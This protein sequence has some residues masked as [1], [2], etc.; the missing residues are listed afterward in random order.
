MKRAICLTLFVA[1]TSL[2]HA[3]VLINEEF[4]Q[5]TSGSPVGL[6]GKA[7]T[8][9]TITESW[10]ADSSLTENGTEASIPYVP[11][12]QAIGYL[13][14]PGAG[15]G[16]TVGDTYTLSFTLGPVSGAS[17]TS[18]GFGT[19]STT[20][21]V[22]YT[23]PNYGGFWVLNNGGAIALYAN[24][25][26]GVPNQIGGFPLNS[27]GVGN[28]TLKITV[29]ATSDQLSAIVNGHSVSLSS[30]NLSLSP[31]TDVFI[32]HY[33]AAGTFSDLLLTAPEPSTW[34]MMLLGSAGLLVF[35][36]W[37]ALKA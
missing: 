4:T 14:I 19:E 13:A 17:W 12:N 11:S 21:D 8:Y 10:T 31:I 6:N 7:P 30:S 32:G 33:E 9:S 20:S 28:V 16:L 3:Q 29:G 1:L 23:G 22:T 15:L 2:G 24:S 34:A 27:D 26:L 5:G 36:R 35:V 18:A 25:A 37:R